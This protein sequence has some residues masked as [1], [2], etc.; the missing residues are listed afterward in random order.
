MCNKM[1]SEEKMWVWITGLFVGLVVVVLYTCMCWNTHN[2]KNF[3][4]GGYTRAML[5]GIVSP[6]WVLPEGDK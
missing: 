3:I 6:Q 4:D 2:V 1:D 5:P